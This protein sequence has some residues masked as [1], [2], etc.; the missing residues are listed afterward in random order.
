MAAAG[1]T[2]AVALPSAPAFAQPAAAGATTLLA[3]LAVLALLFFAGTAAA[4]GWMWWRE[5]QHR[6]ALERD[7]ARHDA[8]ARAVPL[9]HCGWGADGATS[10]SPGFSALIG[11]PPDEPGA[12]P[13]DVPTS[14]TIETALDPGDAAAFHSAFVRLRADGDPFALEVTTAAG[15]AGDPGRRL[16]LI[17]RRG[18]AA[19]APGSGPASQVASDAGTFDVLWVQDIEDHARAVRQHADRLVEAERLQAELCAMLDALPLPVWLRERDQTLGWVNTAYADALELPRATVLER[20]VEIGQGVLADSGRAL[21]LAAAAQGSA[22]QTSRHAVFN[23]ARRLIRFTETPVP[24]S[25]AAARL[26]IGYA[27]DLTD[28]DEARAEL[29]RHVVAHGQVLEQL[30]SAIAI[31]AADGRLTF[32][33][34]AYVL[35]WGFEERW[36]DSG[37]T[38]GEMLEDL[39]SRR[40]LPEYADFPAFKREQLALFI[41]LIDARETLIHLPDDTTLRE[42]VTP[43]PFGGLLFVQEDVTSAIALERNYNTLMAVQQE[44]L[45]H[46]AEAVAVFGSDGR[47]RLSNPSYRRLWDLPEERVE[48]RPHAADLIDHSRAL[49]ETGADWSRTRKEMIG[50]ALRRQPVSLR[51]RRSDGRVLDF[52]TVPLP[53]GGVLHS[54]QDVTD[55]A[56]VE[57]ALRTSNE[58]LEA[59]DRLKTEFIA[60]VSYQ[61]RT[62][63]NAISGFAEILRDGYFGMLNPRQSGYVADI[64][65]STQR[66]LALIN[67]ILDLATIEAGYLAL[68]LDTVDVDAAVRGVVELTRSWAEGLGLSVTLAPTIE[69]RAVLADEKR[70]KQ[71]IYNLVSNAV[72]FTPPGGEIRLSA[73]V[74]D[75]QVRLSVSDTGIGIPES[76]QR[77]VFGRFEKA[78]TLSRQS[79]AGLGLALVKSIIELHGG[80]VELESQPGAGTT[81]HCLLPIAEIPIALQVV[82]EAREEEE[83]VPPLPAASPF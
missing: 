42:I 72:K 64:I 3:A 24:G 47:L 36:L 74:C 56:R 63:L 60:H 49:L 82:R 14:E 28:W 10:H 53:D 29:A 45:D 54:Y 9:E 1:G 55:S 40:R 52:N 26:I 71:A 31:F 59:A 46:L 58:A 48:G 4:L 21:A 43:H 66:L 69:A 2:A 41:T 35:L 50:F 13:A 39:R 32:F 62:P 25:G 22:Q 38:Y 20:Q 5:R 83:D 11:L 67:D 80:R 15:G 78:D 8:F 79:G 34:Q 17:G 65:D 30:R 51:M 27:E 16:R 23:G 81:V 44:S 37:P 12:R 61:L 57:Q 18:S 33:N 70:L 19:R 76:D 68:D 6:A 7:L 77:R 75:N 73:T